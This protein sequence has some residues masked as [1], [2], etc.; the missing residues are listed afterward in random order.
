[1]D[2]AFRKARMD[3]AEMLWRWANDPGTRRNSFSTSPIPYGDHVAWLQQ[4]L[5]SAATSIWIFSDGPS[6]VGLVRMDVSGHVAEV[7]IT[8]A[9]E[10]RG[11]A[12]G[13]AILRRA[14]CLL[15][16]E[17]GDRVRARAS[18]LPHNVSSLRLFKG[19]GFQE[20]R[21]VQRAQGQQ[22]IV[23]ELRD[24]AHECERGEHDERERDE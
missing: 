8:V 18:V 3:D 11:R 4:Q 17:R 15:R 16:E 13:T 23:L 10:A 14:L 24:G 1:M 22:T 7:H 21:G 12:Y 2:L 9:P 20:I 5:G 19:C 6:P